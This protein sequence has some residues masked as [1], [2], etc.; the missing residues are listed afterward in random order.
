MSSTAV[1][2]IEN[3]Q[4]EN[5]QSKKRTFEQSQCSDIEEVDYR[6]ADDQRVECM[7]IEKPQEMHK[8][9]AVGGKKKKK[10]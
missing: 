4:N 9:K 3:S 7:I 8:V 6:K 2:N 1:E 5:I 10:L